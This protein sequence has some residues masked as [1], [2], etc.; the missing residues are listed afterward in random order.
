MSPEVPPPVRA[1]ASELGVLPSSTPVEIRSAYLK[2]VKQRKPEV[3]PEGFRRTREAYETLSGWAQFVARRER[4]AAPRAQAEP[5]PPSA[6]PASQAPPPAAAPEPVSAPGGWQSLRSLLEQKNVSGA[7][8]LIRQ[9]LDANV[10]PPREPGPI[11]L[12][13]LLLAM[14]AEAPGPEARA[15]MCS[16]VGWIERTQTE[17]VFREVMDR[18]LPA[19]DLGWAPVELPLAVEAL[20]ARGLL[21]GDTGQMM[22]RIEEFTLE[23]RHQAGLALASLARHTPTLRVFLAPVLSL[24][25]IRRRRP[26]PGKSKWGTYV[27]VGASLGFFTLWVLVDAKIIAKPRPSQDGTSGLG[28]RLPPPPAVP[29]PEDARAVSLAV[30]TVCGA[31][32]G[33]D[34]GAAQRLRTK[35]EEHNCTGA[36][37]QL[38]SLVTGHFAGDRE[39]AAPTLGALRD[40]IMAC[41]KKVD[42]T[43]PPPPPPAKVEP[44][45]E[46]PEAV[47]AAVAELCRYPQERLCDFAE[48]VQKR[49]AEH[50]CGHA[51]MEL[52]TV[53]E[54]LGPYS[55]PDLRKAAA[56]LLQQTALC[57][58]HQ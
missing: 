22:R 50:K 2:L 51:R 12:L 40:Q 55:R 5:V 9:Q 7:R 27:A 53:E 39:H 34:C 43:S 28:L 56:T 36:G 3:D 15:T 19:R 30:A 1:A 10:G 18:W 21:D 45:P 17:L 32:P 57:A 26:V 14:Q 33:E 20:V 4:A 54:H 35:L 47:A 49:L 58:Q 24:D 48:R 11:G 8:A 13:K 46:D 41:F 44:P 38:Q 16:F 42:E 52:T 31:S 29:P 23:H 25:L 6:P 37:L